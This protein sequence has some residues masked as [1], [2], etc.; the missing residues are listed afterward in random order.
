M[1][2]FL[3][4]LGD[5][6]ELPTQEAQRAWAESFPLP[7]DQ[8]QPSSGL[9][10]MAWASANGNFSC[11]APERG[12]I[13]TELGTGARQSLLDEED[14]RQRSPFLSDLP[15]APWDQAMPGEESAE[16]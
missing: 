5:P 9:S 7:V 1:H 4:F 11:G 15:Q 10:L 3:S 8:E 12:G 2:T 14:I 6:G 13:A 16:G